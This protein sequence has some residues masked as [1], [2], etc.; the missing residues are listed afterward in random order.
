MKKIYNYRKAT[1]FD[2]ETDGLLDE[3]SK[4]HILGFKMENLGI[5]TI[6]GSN[7][8]RIKA[9]LA[10]H[11]EN[12][13]PVACHNS[14]SYDIPALE[15]VLGLDLSK[16]MVINTLSLSW[17][18]NINHNKHSLEA[19]SH[20]Y[21]VPEKY[22][23]ADDAWENLSYD[24]AVKRVTSD[25]AINTAVYHDFIDRLEGM[26][27]AAKKVIDNGEVGGKRTSPE[28]IIYLDSLVGIS[29]EEHVNR[30][31]TFLMFKD[32]VM[33]LQEKTK[34]DVDIPYL[35]EN[36][37]KLE[38]LV[39]DSANKLEAVMPK[40]PK[41]TVR[42]KPKVMFKKNGDMSVAGEKW[43]FLMARNN[44]SKDSFGNLI[45]RERNGVFEELT[46][47]EEPNI[48]SSQQVK[49]FL[50]S[51]GWKPATFKYVR[52]KKDFSAWVESRPKEGAAHWEWTEW[53]DKKPEDRA[54]PQ[55]RIDGDDGKELC[56]SVEELAETVNEIRYLEEYSVIKH[57][58]DSLKGILSR[59]DKDGK[60]ESSWHGLTNT[61]R[62]KHRAPIVNLP[63]STK[64]YAE[65][66]RGCLIAPDK[67]I[68]CGSDLSSL[69]DRVKVMFMMPHDPEYATLM[70]SDRFCPHLVTAVAMGEI[71]DEQ[72]FAYIDKTLDD[73]ERAFVYSK[74][75]DAKPV[76]YLSVYG[77]T[78]KALQ[79]QTGW[80]EKRC[81]D[82]IEAYWDKNWSVKA[83][84]D[85]QVVVKCPKGL[86][87]LVNPINGFCYSVRSDKD[88]FSTL[89]Q[90]TGSYLF[91]MWIDKILTK[92]E[93]IWNKKTITSTY[94]DEGVW[95]H[96]DTEELR[97]AFYK[98]IKDS[99]KEVSEEYLLRRS[100]DCEVDFGKRY[101]D[102]G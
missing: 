12:E 73:T 18:L 63:A 90:G 94:H 83:I 71:S 45:V 51:H 54:V 44:G 67:F 34:W 16:L 88:K 72:M 99:I 56:E 31:L 61:L 87:W 27:A 52:N 8:E 80:T 33:A 76:N 32:D 28:E 7:H 37:A 58:Y 9:M 3:V 10:W 89:A 49:E 6:L 29:V 13:I 78:W 20:E 57:R 96:R 48:N 82:A 22:A 70:S 68:T 95:V 1:V 101:S 69:E 97:E 66:I 55:V 100:L 75:S 50:F 81:K 86:S 46:S 5:K 41:Y 47:L 24:D 35:E 85:E 36:I 15:K 53:K 74:R 40:I 11:I 17:Y 38:I 91:D 62:V 39:V 77:G 59:C 60:V 79:R 84:A 92:Q 21:D 2:I 4:I 14:I 26:A 93:E 19:L 23:V 25:V 30:I 98:I 102:V 65:A 64:K 42:N 43:T